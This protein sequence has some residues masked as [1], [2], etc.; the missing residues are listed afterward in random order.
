MSRRPVP[1]PSF[2]QITFSVFL[3]M[4]TL[5]L[6]GFFVFF[7][8]VAAQSPE[9]PE[10]VSDVAIVLTGGSGRIE[11]GFD[12]IVKGG[13][14]ALLISGVHES[15]KLKDLVGMWDADNKE[16]NTIL[17]HC[18]IYMD[19]KAESTESNASETAAWIKNKDIK[20]VRI[21]SSD[22]HIPRAWLLFRRA[23]PDKELSVWP[24]SSLS[25]LSPVF[26]RNILTEYSKT[27]LTWLS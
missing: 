27:L 6:L 16:R 15:V 8:I 25:K 17:T 12:L 13:S 1:L 5:W 20:T 19:Y 14:K 10:S 26:W 21:I 18:C 2:V 7:G 24:V 9:N 11:S 22:Y 3:G 4:V 23:M